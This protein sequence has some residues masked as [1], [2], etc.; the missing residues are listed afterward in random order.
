MINPEKTYQQY[1]FLKLSSFKKLLVL[2]L[3]LSTNI[4]FAQ[5]ENKSTLFSTFNFGVYGGINFAD[6]SEIGGVFSIEGKTNLTTNLNLK[7]SLGY[8]KSIEL[9]NYTL[10]S[11]GMNRIDTLT[12]YSASE[13]YITERVYDVLPISIGLQY[14]F[15][16]KTISPYILLDGS[17]NYIDTKRTRNGGKSWSYNT[18]EEVPDKFKN[19]PNQRF[20]NESFGIAFGLGVLYNIK[21]SLNIDFRY[22]FIYDN[23]IINSH[24]FLVGFNF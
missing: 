2:L 17:Y 16:N 23:E 14:V 19:N 11:S 4:F 18:Y 15:R 8:Y 6:V 12:Y 7:F 13:E 24:Q 10:R 5:A 22:L 21:K 1:L 9:V 20:Y 3:F